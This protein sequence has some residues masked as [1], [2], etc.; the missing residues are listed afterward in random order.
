[1]GLTSILSEIRSIDTM[2]VLDKMKYHLDEATDRDNAKGIIIGRA[3]CLA[4][5]IKSHRAQDNE[6]VFLSVLHELFKILRSRDYLRQ[7]AVELIIQLF[8][9]SSSLI[10]E[11]LR[12][13]VNE[14]LTRIGPELTTDPDLA[15]LLFRTKQLGL[16]TDA[17]FRIFWGS[18]DI[19]VDKENVKGKSGKCFDK[20]K[21]LLNDAT[22]RHPKRHP[23]VD[24]ICTAALQTDN[25]EDFWRFYEK[26]LPRL[27]WEK[28]YVVMDGE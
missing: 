25:F 18:V 12:E 16:I 20:L 23:V 11:A 17:Q 8:V 19:V 9:S 27:S 22:K 5:I 2:D 21:A 14:K 15:L 26:D 10:T 28:K 24:V 13:G 7:L 3:F 4:A 6:K 1:M